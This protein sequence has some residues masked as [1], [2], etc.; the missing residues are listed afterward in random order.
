MWRDKD[1]IIEIVL[2]ECLKNYVEGEIGKEEL[3]D[4]NRWA[5]N[6]NVPLHQLQFEKELKIY[7]NLLTINLPEIENELNNEWDK[8]SSK[9]FDECEI[10]TKEV[11]NNKYGAINKLEKKIENLKDNICSWILLNRRSMWT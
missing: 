8:L 4:K 1:S 6:N 7:Y 3:F 11:F 2:F 5:K 10:V 9:Y